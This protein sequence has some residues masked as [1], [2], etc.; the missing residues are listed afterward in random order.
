MSA[1][2]YTIPAEPGRGG[3][4]ALALLMHLALAFFLWSGIRWQNDAPITVEAEV[5]DTKIQQ[6]APKAV[7][8]PPPVEIKPEPKPEPPP[9]VKPVERAPDIALER[10]K[11]LEK[12]REKKLEK[13]R[14]EKLAAEEKEKL[15]K[16]EEQKLLDKK[17]QDKLDKA[18]KAKEQAKR[19]L[20]EKKILE[21]IRAKTIQGFTGNG[22]ASA[23]GEAA[24]ST[25][26]RG[27]P[28]YAQAVRAKIKSALNF[29][30]DNVPGNPKVVFKIDLLPSGDVLGVKLVKSSGIPAFD[31]AVEKAINK[32]SPLPKKKDGSVDRDIEVTYNLKE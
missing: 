5:W 17:K 13:L 26:P 2:A 15:A 28:N 25:G 7:P 10:E 4:L 16:L 30:G 24:R 14:L 22:N 6:A 11:K 12:E 23:T 20:A 3:A 27:D 31:D 1:A 32:A 21:D 19:D 18:E 8:P 9:V 29:G